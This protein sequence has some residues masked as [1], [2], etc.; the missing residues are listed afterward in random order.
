MTAAIGIRA[1]K[2]EI[3]STSGWP[4]DEDEIDFWRDQ[5]IALF[6]NCPKGAGGTVKIVCARRS[7]RMIRA[8]SGQSVVRQPQWTPSTSLRGGSGIQLQ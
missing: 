7:G 4:T 5:A 2:A 6:E 8:E 1:G 3:Y